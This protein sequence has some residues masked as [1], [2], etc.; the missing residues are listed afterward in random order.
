MITNEA[1]G[2]KTNIIHVNANSKIINNKVIISSR[3]PAPSLKNPWGGGGGTIPPR[4][5]LPREKSPHPKL[6]SFS[7]CDF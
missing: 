1:F 4:K 2:I 3:K 5:N 7:F 6:F